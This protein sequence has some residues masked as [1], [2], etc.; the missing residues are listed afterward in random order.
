MKWKRGILHMLQKTLPNPPQPEF[1]VASQSLRIYPLS[2]DLA[3]LS[4][5]KS[6]E[7]LLCA[8]DTEISDI[9]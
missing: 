2:D 6:S 4:V 8:V 5:D 3:I 1:R 7:R 9:I